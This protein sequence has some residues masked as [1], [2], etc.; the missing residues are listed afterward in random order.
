LR[1]ARAGRS[2]VE[3][4]SAAAVSPETLRKIETGRLAAPSFATVAKVAH[5][6][7]LSLD[8]VAAHAMPVGELGQSA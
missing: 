7:D 6:L 4:A 3:V 5:A 8:D 2:I 1:D